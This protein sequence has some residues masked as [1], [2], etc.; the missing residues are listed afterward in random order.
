MLSVCLSFYGQQKQV[1]QGH[2]SS[3][4]WMNRPYEVPVPPF[5][6]VRCG[7]HP[8]P[9]WLCT[10]GAGI[11]A[12]LVMCLQGVA[13]GWWWSVPRLLL[14]AFISKGQVAKAGCCF[15]FVH[16]FVPFYLFH[17]LQPPSFFRKSL[18]LKVHLLSLALSLSKGL[19]IL[20]WVRG[21]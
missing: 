4:L 19:D 3:C 18:I 20:L 8:S 11:A 6:R 17:I 16:T 5:P 7:N 9:S 2:D 12:W 15:I 14:G 10:Y 21:P 13:A 1:F